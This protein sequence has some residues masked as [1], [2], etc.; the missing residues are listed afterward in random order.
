ML[1]LYNFTLMAENSPME[2]TADE[3]LTSFNES[4]A[5]MNM[6][7]TSMS[8]ITTKEL[9]IEET[10]SFGQATELFEPPQSEGCAVCSCS[11]LFVL[12]LAGFL[13]LMIE[14]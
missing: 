4:T 8:E 3:E 13:C 6:N 5:T 14:Y 10:S 11:H 7:I 9:Y 12:I 1:K 2:T